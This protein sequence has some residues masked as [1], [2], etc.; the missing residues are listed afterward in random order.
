[1]TNLEEYNRAMDAIRDE[2]AKSQDGKIAYLGEGL[3][4]ML[5]LCPEY[6]GKIAAKGKTLS[7]A[8]DAIRKAAKGG[9][10]DPIQ[11]TTAIIGYYGLD[12]EDA[13]TLAVRVNLAMMGEKT[14]LPQTPAEPAQTPAE[15][16]PTPAE[17]DPYDLDALLGGL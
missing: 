12:C 7:G 13:R 17:A 8:M 10:A 16:A 3:T 9:V 11:S 15:A 4:A 1:M 5:K 2:M 6:A 14:T